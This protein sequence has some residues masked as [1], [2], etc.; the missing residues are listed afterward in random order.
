[1]LKFVASLFPLFLLVDVGN[2]VVHVAVFREVVCPERLPLVGVPAQPVADDQ[3]VLFHPGGNVRQ[4][5]NERLIFVVVG[6]GAVRGEVQIVGFLVLGQWKPLG[7]VGLL[8]DELGILAVDALCLGDE[9]F[10]QVN[11]LVGAQHARGQQGDLEVPQ[12]RIAVPH[13]G[14]QFIAIGTAAS[15]IHDPHAL[16]ARL[17]SLDQSLRGGGAGRAA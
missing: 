7:E 3:A 5:S 10:V 1:M 2:D 11:A 4:E 12:V 14:E 13:A 9:L 16:H 6:T 17:L 8:E 15:Q